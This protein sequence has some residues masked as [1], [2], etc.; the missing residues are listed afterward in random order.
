M[1]ADTGPNC[2]DTVTMEDSGSFTSADPQ[3][4]VGHPNETTPLIPEVNS[5]N[6]QRYVSLRCSFSVL[7]CLLLVAQVVALLS[8]FTAITL[9]LLETNTTKSHQKSGR[10]ALCV[11]K[12]IAYAFSIFYDFIG[13]V[14]CSIYIAIIVK[15]PGFVGYSTVGR[16]LIHLPKFWTLVIL[17]LLYLLGALLTII[18]DITNWKESDDSLCKNFVAYLKIIGIVIEMIHCC[19]ITILIGFLNYTNIKNITR[20]GTNVLLKRALVVFCVCFAI[21]CLILVFEIGFILQRTS[22]LFVAIGEFLLL[23]FCQKV[24]ELL[25]KKIFHN[26]KCIIGKISSQNDENRQH[27]STV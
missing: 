26:D 19:F 18:L 8:C 22:N 24:I 23:P 17:L 5:S 9:S 10:C 27:T 13:T 11:Y 2:V 25:W 16:N 1:A 7:Y 4:D 20:N 15:P 14:N 12:E 21:S 3:S 6:R